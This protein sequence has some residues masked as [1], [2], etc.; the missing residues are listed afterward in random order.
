MLFLLKLP[1]LLSLPHSQFI[2]THI[3]IIKS[4][5]LLAALSTYSASPSLVMDEQFVLPFQGQFI[6]S[7]HLKNFVSL[8]IYTLRCFLSSGK[9]PLAFKCAETWPAFKKKCK[10]KIHLPIT[11]YPVPSITPFFFFCFHLL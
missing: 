2:E 11:P 1:N 3:P 10:E 4:T 7:Y 8:I 9:F 6:S 5:N